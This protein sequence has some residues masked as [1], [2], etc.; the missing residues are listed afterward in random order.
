MFGSDNHL[1]ILAAL[2]VPILLVCLFFLFTRIR[3]RILEKIAVSL[4]FGIDRKRDRF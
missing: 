1:L 2:F 4:F 3:D